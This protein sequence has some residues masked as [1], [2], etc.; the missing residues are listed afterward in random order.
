MTDKDTLRPTLRQLV[1][2]RDLSEEEAADVMRALVAGAFT[3]AQFGALA[4]G[5]RLKGE[6]AAEIAGFIQVLRDQGV[7]VDLGARAKD[8]VDMCG[9]GG[10]GPSSQV[11]NIST[12]AL[13]VAAGAGATVAKH[14]TNAVSSKSGSSDV[15]L[16]LGVAPARTPGEAAE[17]L[18]SLGICYM[19]APSF[20]AG[21]RHLIGLRQEIG[22]RTVFNLLGPLCNPARVER[23]LTGVYDGRYVPVVAE[24]LARCGTRRAWVV[25][26]ADGLD[27]LSTVDRSRV[28]EVRDG[29]LT[30]FEV[31]P[32]GLGLAPARHDELRGGLPA[33]NA[34]ILRTVLSGT[35]TGAQTDVVLLNAA[36]VLVVGGQADDLAH[37]LQLAEKSVR[38]GAATDVLDRWVSWSATR[39]RTHAGATS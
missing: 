6:R 37:G 36:G 27:E 10:D 1:T 24:A 11:F 17:S 34:R 38:S 8:A 39:S 4:V 5:L 35:A 13:F 23:H 28:V 3:P 21:M 22:L 2:G 26:G 14:G 30:E 7:R 9:T 18:T 25:H 16:A 12:T 33:E 32:R 19:H 31:D 29:T 20:N 15:L